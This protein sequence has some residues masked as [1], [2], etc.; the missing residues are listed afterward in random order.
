MKEYLIN[1]VNDLR[2]F[3]NTLN[4][5]AL[6]L[7]KPWALIDSDLGIQKIIFNANKDL[8]LSRDG[9]VTIGKWEYLSE[10]RSLL[11]DRVT[12]K[13]LCREEY[14]DDHI[15]ILRRDGTKDGFI[16]L[17]NENK[18]PTLDAY[19]YLIDLSFEKKGV[20]YIELSDNRNI[21][22]ELNGNQQIGIGSPVTCDGKIISDGIYDIKG[23]VTQYVIAKGKIVDIVHYVTLES[24]EGERLLSNTTADLGLSIGDRILIE[25]NRME[26]IDGTFNVI[27]NDLKMRVNIIQGVIRKIKYIKEYELEKD[28]D[29]IF[30][31]QFPNSFEKDDLV[32]LNGNPPSN[33][34]IKVGSDRI[35]VV[36]GI[37]KSVKDGDLVF[38]GF[39]ILGVSLLIFLYWY[40]LF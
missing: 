14:V 2:Q 24:E 19:N 22:A 12:D 25:R 30:Y 33:C 6:L 23:G 40:F 13:I 15:L 11:L 8:I 39:L 1:I 20:R 28:R 21:C 5:K 36:N 29:Y 17:A 26:I 18:L 38:G 27:R 10:A 3:S 4:K 9:N 31:C 32:F 7:N 34:K 16:V 37:V 35:K